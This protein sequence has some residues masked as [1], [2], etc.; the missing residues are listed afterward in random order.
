MKEKQL[1]VRKFPGDTSVQHVARRKVSEITRP[2]GKR[3]RTALTIKII[4]EW[5][6]VENLQIRSSST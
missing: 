3:K 5:K 6:K 1:K 4:S 2:E